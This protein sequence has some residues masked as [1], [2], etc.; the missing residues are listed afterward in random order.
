VSGDEHGFRFRFPG[1]QPSPPSPSGL[2]DFALLAEWGRD[3]HIDI[4]IV[5]PC[6]DRSSRLYAVQ[7]RGS[8]MVASL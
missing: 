2:T 6:M 4:Q 7:S 1:M 3:R 8:R 5:G